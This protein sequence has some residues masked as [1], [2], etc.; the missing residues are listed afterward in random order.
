[1]KEDFL[2]HI[3]TFKGMKH[4]KMSRERKVKDLKHAWQN[5]KLGGNREGTYDEKDEPS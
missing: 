5:K 1:M 3:T 2:C 4:D